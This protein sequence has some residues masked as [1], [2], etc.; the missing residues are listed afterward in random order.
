MGELTSRILPTT[1]VHIWS[2]SRV[3]AQSSTRR[4][5]HAAEFWCCGVTIA[6]R[7]VGQRCSG[8]V[9]SARQPA[10]HSLRWLPYAGI[11]PAA[12][13]M[14]ARCIRLYVINVVLRL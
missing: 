13:I 12:V 9:K 14:R 3:G 4:L 11:P 7:F 8:L 5:G 1:W 6:P 10:S 2:V